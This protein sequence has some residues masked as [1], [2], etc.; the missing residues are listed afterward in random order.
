MG[1]FKG[2]PSPLSCRS[3]LDA[4][5]MSILLYECEN[6]LM[7]HA[8]MEKVESFQAEEQY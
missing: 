5:V 2:D 3:I 6:W 8:L 4:C 7:T 1:A